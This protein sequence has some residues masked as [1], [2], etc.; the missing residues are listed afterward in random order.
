MSFWMALPASWEKRLFPSIQTI[1]RQRTKQLKI[2][3]LQACAHGIGLLIYSLSNPGEAWAGTKVGVKDVGGGG[4]GGAHFN[5]DRISNPVES[6]SLQGEQSGYTLVK[7]SAAKQQLFCVC[8]WFITMSTTAPHIQ[9]RPKMSDEITVS[10]LRLH[11]KA[12]CLL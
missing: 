12:R 8:Q 2:H 6:L 10:G 4:S 7:L 5:N 9:V 1:M 11:H 3:S